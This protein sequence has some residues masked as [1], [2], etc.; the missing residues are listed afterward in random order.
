MHLGTSCRR[1]WLA[2]SALVA[3]IAACEPATPEVNNGA[4]SDATADLTVFAAAS[5]SGPFEAIGDAFGSRHPQITVRFNFAGSQTLAR[6]INEGAAADVVA[7]AHVDQIAPLAATGQL[8]GDI[9]RFASNRLVIAVEPSN[10]LG[11]TRLEDL[12]RDDVIVVLP[13]E[14]VPAG[15]YAR[16][17]LEAANLTLTPASWERDVRGALAQVQ[18]GEADAAIVYASD[19][20]AS[21]GR[22]EG[23][24][25]ISAVDVVAHYPI[26]VLRNA[27]DPQVAQQFVAFVLSEQGQAI[28]RTYGFAAPQ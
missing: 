23:I 24:E 9:V 26:G 7:S 27:Q 3:V 10:P 21:A 5:L 19:I 2:L 6:Q 12:T 22:A 1:L 18:R 15:T 4:T 13:A 8:A 11:I 20:V 25:I 14:D 16:Q 17:L 28:L